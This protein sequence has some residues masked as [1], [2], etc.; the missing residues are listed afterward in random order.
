MIQLIKQIQPETLLVGFKLLV[1]VSKQSL[2]ATARESMKN[3]QADY[4]LANDLA[5]ITE[6]QHIGYF[7]DRKGQILGEKHTKEDLAILI[8]E[9]I[10]SQNASS[11]RR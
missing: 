4:I 3:N 2:I 7:I 11:Y 8:A 9:T 6:E 10:L 1:D 5:K